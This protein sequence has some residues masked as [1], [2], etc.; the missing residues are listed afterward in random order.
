M[1]CLKLE[2][3]IEAEGGDEEECRGDLEEFHREMI[4]REFMSVETRKA[5]VIIRLRIDLFAQGKFP[6]AQDAVAES[7]FEDESAQECRHIERPEFRHEPA[8]EH[9]CKNDAVDEEN[10]VGE[11][12]YFGHKNDLVSSCDFSKQYN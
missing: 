2:I 4:L 1:I 3:D 6:F 10:A 7:E 8:E 12:F 5:V 11:K 9:Y